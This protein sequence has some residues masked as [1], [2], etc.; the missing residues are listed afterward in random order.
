L[1]TARRVKAA[2]HL[3]NTVRPTLCHM[4]ELREDLEHPAYIR[5]VDKNQREALFVRAEVDKHMEIAHQR[6]RFSGT[7][8]RKHTFWAAYCPPNSWPYQDTPWVNLKFGD[9]NLKSNSKLKLLD[10]FKYFEERP[11]SAGGMVM[12]SDVPIKVLDLGKFDD[13]KILFSEL[14]W[15]MQFTAKLEVDPY[16]LQRHIKLAGST[17]VLELAGCYR[18]KLPKQTRQ[19]TMS[20]YQTSTILN[21]RS[22]Q[23]LWNRIIKKNKMTIINLKG[24][25]TERIE[26]WFK[27]L[28]PYTIPDRVPWQPRII[29]SRVF[30]TMSKSRD[31]QKLQYKWI[32]KYLNE[33]IDTGQEETWYNTV[34]AI[35]DKC[36]SIAIMMAVLK[37]DG[38]WRP[39]QI[40]PAFFRIIGSRVRYK[41]RDTMTAYSQI[42]FDQ[43]YAFT[44]ERSVFMIFKLLNDWKI[45]R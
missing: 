18:L 27:K 7:Y 24:Q 9:F 15:E 35:W 28:N 34:K 31:I 33:L 8:N 10:P 11:G 22:G 39:L 5:Y 13:H 45:F 3:L 30:T 21:T 43:Q 41:W 32:S 37:P 12:A 14:K 2:R 6:H 26:Q 25:H 4:S 23:Q 29:P 19:A 44:K 40:I 42:L 1:E 38:D 20:I 16:L 36:T 17:K